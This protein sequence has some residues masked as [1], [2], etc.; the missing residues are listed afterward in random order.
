MFYTWP[1][2]CYQTLE[3]NILKMNKPISIQIGTCGLRGKDV[4]WPALGARTSQ[5]K[6]TVSRTQHFKNG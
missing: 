5:V 4:K 2:M 6:V 3:H 1:F